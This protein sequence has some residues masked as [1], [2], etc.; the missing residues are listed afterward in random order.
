MHLQVFKNRGK[1][2]VR[3]VESY[4][5][6]K[7]KKPKL[8]VIQ[9]FGSKEKLLA[10]NP[11]ALKELEE[12]VK[13]MNAER[14]QANASLLAHRVQKFVGSERTNSQDQGAPVQ[15]YGYEIY[16]MLWEELKLDYFFQ[17]RQK[18]DTE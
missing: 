16:R 15:N 8:R 17:Y 18:R 4:R 5:D 9:A 2:Y 13:R 7:T 6:P 10:E 1:E 11:N 14:N 3:I 12:K